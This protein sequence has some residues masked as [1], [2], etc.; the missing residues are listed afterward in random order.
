MKVFGEAFSNNTWLFEILSAWKDNV[1]VKICIV[2]FTKQRLRYVETTSLSYI[3]TRIPDLRVKLV[4]IN[5]QGM[6]G[7]TPEVW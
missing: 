2:L 3:Q 7:L 5:A 1:H 4:S 6:I